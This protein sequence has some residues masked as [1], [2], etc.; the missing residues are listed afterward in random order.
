MYVLKVFDKILENK[1]TSVPNNSN[2]KDYPLLWT[3][4]YMPVMVKWK[5]DVHL[6]YLQATNIVIKYLRKNKL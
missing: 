4:C 2:V 3:P 6:P 1:T 5:Q